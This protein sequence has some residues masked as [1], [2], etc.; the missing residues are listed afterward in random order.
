MTGRA[1]TASWRDHCRAEGITEPQGDAQYEANETV[2]RLCQAPVRPG[3]PRCPACGYRAPC[4]IGLGVAFAL[5]F[6]V[7]MTALPPVRLF[8]Y[9]L[10]IAATTRLV[11]VE[12]RSLAVPHDD[13]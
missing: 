8:G 1:G 2:C 10:L 3:E 6:G 4:G 13:A 7:G 12:Q 11:T 5:A 9:L